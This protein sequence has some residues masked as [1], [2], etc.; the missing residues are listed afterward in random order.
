MMR[1]TIGTYQKIIHGK[2]VFVFFNWN[3]YTSAQYIKDFKEYKK[4]LEG[5]YSL[6]PQ[7]LTGLKTSLQSFPEDK[8]FLETLKQ[9]IE[10]DLAKHPKELKDKELI[11]FDECRKTAEEKV[12]Q[13]I[14]GLF[15]QDEK[16][17]PPNQKFS[18]EITIEPVENR[19]WYFMHFFSKAKNLVDMDKG[20]MFYKI[21][22]YWLLHNIVI[23]SCHL[24]DDPS[25]LENAKVSILQQLKEHQDVIEQNLIDDTKLGTELKAYLKTSDSRNVRYLY[26]TLNGVWTTTLSEFYSVYNAKKFI[27]IPAGSIH[28]YRRLLEIL[29]VQPQ[30]KVTQFYEEHIGY[31]NTGV[32]SEYSMGRIVGAIAAAAA[33]EAAIKEKGVKFGKKPYDLFINGKV[34]EAKNLAERSKLINDAITNSQDI[35]IGNFDQSIVNGVLSVIRS[36]KNLIKFMDYVERSFKVFNI[37]PKNQIYNRD[38]FNILIKKAN[39]HKK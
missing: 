22:R 37:T 10:Y 17:M 12:S 8:V 14:I 5:F 20:R 7:A 13:I 9:E 15:E 24:P 4:Y 28:N 2:E 27:T 34:I 25:H 21:S 6:H 11:S 3:N 30:N 26:M 35:S 32:S 23:P 31:Q 18:V 33:S 39:A 36:E 16:L 1:R 29:A 19:D 38:M